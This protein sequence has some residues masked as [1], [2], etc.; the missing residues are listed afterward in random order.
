ML[1]IVMLAVGV[2]LGMGTMA[3]ASGDGEVY[4]ACV[5]PN[6]G[7]I[8]MIAADE[9][10]KQHETRMSWN[11]RGPQGLTGEQGVPG[12]QGPEGPAGPQGL[13]G[14]PGPQGPQGDPGPVGLS[15]EGL[16]CANQSILKAEF[17]GFQVSASCPALLKKSPDVASVQI[18]LGSIQTFEIVNIGGQPAHAITSVTFT[19]S[20]SLIVKVND[21]CVSGRVLGAGQ[22]CAVMLTRQPSPGSSSA[23][24]I[25]HFA[26]GQQFSWNVFSGT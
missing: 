21:N 9:S 11:Q 1:A 13:Q 12:E 10:C 3:V 8:K 4:Y 23:T 17:S 16:S 20:N 19:T 6:S 25:V 5:N 18:P 22:S 14:E 7:T 2:G 26:N 24:L 15:G